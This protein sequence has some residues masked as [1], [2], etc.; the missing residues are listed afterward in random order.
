MKW[1]LALSLV[2]GTAGSIFGVVVQTGKEAHHYQ[3]AHPY[4]GNLLTGSLAGESAGRMDCILQGMEKD[5]ISEFLVHLYKEARAERGNDFRYL[6][7]WQILEVLADLKNYDPQSPLLSFEGVPMT[8]PDNGQPALSGGAIN[9]VFRL[10]KEA[11]IGTT[12]G[13]W[14]AVNIWFAFR[15]AVAHF[16]SVSRYKEL[17]R[18]RMRE[19]AEKGR[20]QIEKAHHDII[21]SRL[22]EDVKILLLR[23]M[24]ET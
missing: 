8:N 16:G 15:N 11:G 13:T 14:Q 7:L 18:P 4:T 5:P 1:L 24:S 9:S 20:S 3:S 6:R 23:R 10:I 21:L 12:E 22:D 17:T 19:W 2:R